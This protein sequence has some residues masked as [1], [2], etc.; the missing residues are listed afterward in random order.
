MIKQQRKITEMEVAVIRAALEKAT[1][2][3]LEDETATVENLM[4][5]SRC[6]CGC[7]TVDFQGPSLDEPSKP[8]ADGIGVTPNGG[9][10]GVIVWGRQG[11]ITGLEIYDLGA[12][13]KDL[14]LPVPDSIKPWEQKFAD[15]TPLEP[16]R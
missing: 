7:A 5:V 2:E 16:T 12:G 10:V 6:D 13:E 8:I 3:P 9:D 15:N 11:R 4:V 14:L 1:I